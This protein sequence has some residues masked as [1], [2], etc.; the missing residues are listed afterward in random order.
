MEKYVLDRCPK[1]ALLTNYKQAYDSARILIP[2]LA[3]I[4]S[5]RIR[6]TVSVE[7]DEEDEPADP[8][9]VLKPLKDKEKMKE[10]DQ[11]VRQRWQQRR[12]HAVVEEEG[13]ARQLE[14][15]LRHDIR[16]PLGRCAPQKKQCGK[17][18]LA[19]WRGSS[20]ERFPYLV[21]VPHPRCWHAGWQPS[22][23]QMPEEML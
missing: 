13:Q 15:H 2:S 8:S 1:Y 9:A 4:R 12:R 16:R 10:S 22:M 6:P 3:D 20:P 11:E 5:K 17:G 19:L 7:S 21:R 23:F 14:R 18:C